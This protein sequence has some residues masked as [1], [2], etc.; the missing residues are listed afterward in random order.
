MKLFWG[1]F[2]SHTDKLMYVI[3]YNEE[4]VPHELN[5][6]DTTGGMME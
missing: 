2:W 4:N 3:N 6:I 5:I 1:Y